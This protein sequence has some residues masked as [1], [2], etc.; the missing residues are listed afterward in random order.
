[1]P[2]DIP[3]PGGLPPQVMQRND[4]AD[5]PHELTPRLEFQALF[6]LLCVAL[7]LD[8]SYAFR[9]NDA[10]TKPRIP[11]AATS[12]WSEDAK[13]IIR[14]FYWGDDET[15]SDL[16][17]FEYKPTGLLVG[18]YKYPMRAATSSTP[19]TPRDFARIVRD[20]ALQYRS[21]D[22]LRTLSKQYAEMYGRLERV[23]VLEMVNDEG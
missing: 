7:D 6:G 9:D 11:E 4:N 3:P 13:C 17:N 8:P 12:G 1:M 21:A 5:Y 2:N 18:W 10:G 16:A 15:I 14:P 20:I 23:A 19:V 22:E